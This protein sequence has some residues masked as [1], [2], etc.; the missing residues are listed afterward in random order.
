MRV[1]VCV[2]ALPLLRFTLQQPD[3]FPVDEGACID[4]PHVCLCVFV[5]LVAVKAIVDV[6]ID[7]SLLLFLYCET[8]GVLIHLA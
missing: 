5:C 7:F 1:C 4:D 8:S 2:F 6:V 3:P